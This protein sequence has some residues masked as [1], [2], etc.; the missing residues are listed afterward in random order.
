LL[1]IANTFLNSLSVTAAALRH[2]QTNAPIMAPVAA[3]PITTKVNL[4]NT[5]ASAHNPGSSPSPISSTVRSCSGVHA[6]GHDTLE[7]EPAGVPEHRLSV[8]PIQVLAVEDSSAGP[9]EVL[10]QEGAALTE[11]LGAQIIDVEEQEVESVKARCSA[12]VAA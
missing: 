4:S 1:V 10:P 2:R 12:A 3:A 6:L 9:P 7:P 5:L 8:L 11:L